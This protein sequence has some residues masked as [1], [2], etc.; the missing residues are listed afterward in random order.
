[1]IAYLLAAAITCLVVG[2]ESFN[3][4]SEIWCRSGVYERVETF[5]SNL[6]KTFGAELTLNE[7]GWEIVQAKDERFRTHLL[8]GAALV[9]G[10][11]RVDCEAEIR[12]LWDGRIIFKCSA[13]PG[14]DATCGPFE[15]PVKRF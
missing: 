9:A 15:D 10:F 3:E 14:K 5:T 1:M 13:S 12:W 8:R 7:K 6:P 2:E 4:G 11:A